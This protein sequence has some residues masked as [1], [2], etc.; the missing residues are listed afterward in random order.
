[1]LVRY[2]SPSHY[3]AMDKVAVNATNVNVMVIILVR[4]VK[5]VL[6]LR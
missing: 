3:S 1:M 6:M 5:T 2:W 4:F